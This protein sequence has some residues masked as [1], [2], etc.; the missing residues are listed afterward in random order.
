MKRAIVAVFLVAILLSGCAE[1]GIHTG[2]G[3]H[4]AIYRERYVAAIMCRSMSETHS[5]G[6]DCHDYYYNVDLDEYG[7]SWKDN[8]SY[9]K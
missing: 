7:L 6:Y 8:W 1:T 5:V 4:Y 2:D 9:I 3:R